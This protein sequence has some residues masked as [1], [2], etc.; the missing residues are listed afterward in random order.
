[1]SESH[2]AIVVDNVSRRFALPRERAS[3]L[4]TLSRLGRGQRPPQLHAL[5]QASCT[6]ARGE[7]VGLVGDNGS[8]KSTLLRLIA[9][10][11]QPDEGSATVAGRAV[12]IASL[13]AGMLD[14]LSVRDNILLFGAIYG[15]ARRRL[16]PNIGEILRWAEIEEFARARLRTLSS[17][18]RARLA[19]SVVRY[20]ETDIFLLDE[21][22][23]AG[24]IHFR[25]KCRAFLDGPTHR[26]RT[27]LVVAHDM[28]FLRSFC[29]RAI[30]LHHGRIAA[31]GACAAV[32]DQYEAHRLGR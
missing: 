7:K 28:S 12:L 11:F 14:D 26:K 32:L 6:I 1:M 20:I 24:D 30:W 16:E 23:T 25:E 13:G 19:F 18:M 27:F 5:S 3:V 31:D 4:T 29:T 9:G 17:G 15:V 10:L 8:G 22:L 21:V 2:P